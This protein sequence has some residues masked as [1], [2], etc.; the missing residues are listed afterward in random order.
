MTAVP[1]EVLSE[2][3]SVEPDQ[4][5]ARRSALAKDLR[6]QG[7][8]D[9][10]KAVAA[11]RRPTLSV[12]AADRL[13]EAAPKE[14]RELL[15]AGGAL[16]E[17]QLAVLE[18]KAVRDF[19]T[20]SA[21]HSAALQRALDAAAAAVAGRGRSL[22]DTERQRLQT[23]LRSVS[24]GAPELRAELEAGRLTADRGPEGFGGLEGFE[25]AA[26]PAQPAAR[27]A[28][29]RRGPDPELIAGARRAREEAAAQA[30]V[31]RRAAA[32]AEDLRERAGRLA[33]QA[34]TAASQAAEAER[35][36]RAEA[37]RA[38]ELERQAEAA[39]AALS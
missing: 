8:P 19:R 3:Y 17:A 2:L 10:A 30:E 22:S 36:A 6:G 9:L 28:P 12:W 15:E 7:K 25:A 24:L 31:A 18:G 21:A 4:F 5:V 34:E 33:R 23:T 16:R 35:R 39:E 27:E 20:L 37:E 32:E 29:A 11:L 14:L 38:E 1:P 13:P 26:P